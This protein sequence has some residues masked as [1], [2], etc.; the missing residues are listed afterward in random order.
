MYFPKLQIVMMDLDFYDKGFRP[1]SI[2]STFLHS[3]RRPVL[4]RSKK[5]LPFLNIRIYITTFWTKID[6]EDLE[7]KARHIWMLL[8][9][10]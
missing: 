7:G 3:E 8:N 9:T 2:T 6:V 5:R 4:T 10:K 1:Y